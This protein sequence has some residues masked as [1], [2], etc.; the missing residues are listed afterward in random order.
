MPLKSL[1]PLA[2]DMGTDSAIS[3]LRKDQHAPAAGILVL[4]SQDW[5][6]LEREKQAGLETTATA[7]T[8]LGE[9]VP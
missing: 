1:K 2:G 8:L 6:I 4:H 3:H 9:H 7:R 5:L